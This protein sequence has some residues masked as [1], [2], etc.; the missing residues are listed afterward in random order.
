MKAKIL[1]FFAALL[2]IVSCEDENS[3]YSYDEEATIYSSDDNVVFR[4]LLIILKPYIV[5]NDQTKFLLVDSIYD[6]KISMNTSQWGIFYSMPVDTS[7]YPN[8]IINGVNVCDEEVKYP[9]I[10]PF[11][12]SDEEITTAGGYAALLNHYFTLEPGYYICSVESFK[13]KMANGA[14]KTVKT[15]IVEAIEILPDSRSMFVGEFYVPINL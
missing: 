13:M 12:R 14:E 7:I 11:Q 2:L 15:N 5:D 6:I 10:A 1:L 9:V 8:E 4:E 3:P